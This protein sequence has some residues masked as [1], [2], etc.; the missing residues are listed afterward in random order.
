MTE[1]CPVRVIPS[2]LVLLFPVLGAV[3]CGGGDPVAISRSRVVRGEPLPAPEGS[4]ERFGFAPAG[5][6]GHEHGASEA[7][8]VGL[9]WAWTL[10]PGWKMLPEKE[11]RQGNFAVEGRPGLDCFLSVLPNLGGGLKPNAD[12]W[13]SQMGLAALAEEEFAALPAIQVLGAPAAVIEIDGT[14]AGMGG[15]QP[16]TGYRLVGILARDGETGLFLKMTGP[17]AEVLVERD[18]FLALAGSLRRTK[19]PAPPAEAAGPTA[20]D[21]TVP[22]GWVKGADRPMREVTLNPGGDESAECFVF[23]LGGGGGGTVANLNRWRN[24]M[25]QGD[26]TPEEIDALPKVTVLGHPVPVVE[27]GGVYTDMSGTSREGYLLLG[28]VAELGSSTVTVKFTGPSSVVRA[29]RGKFLA[30]CASLRPRR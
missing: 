7:G 28:V 12:R 8:R 20:F 16:R 19:A 5:A 9:P 17:A 27:V 24:Q 22:E 13:R 10:P 4:A 26:L 1:R 11:F 18:N 14:F 6:A 3:S 29:E 23:I 2:V 15:G 21:W 25:G 30:F